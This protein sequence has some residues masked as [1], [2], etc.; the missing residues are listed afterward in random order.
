MLIDIYKAL[1]QVSYPV[2]IRPYIKKRIKI[3]KEDPN[4]LNERLGQP[5]L[6]RPEGKLIWMHGASVGETISML[7]LIDKILKEDKNIHVMVT[8]G[9]VTSADVMSKRLPERAFHQYIPIDNPKFVKNFIQHWQPDLALWFEAE[10]WPSLISEIHKNKIPLVLVNGRIADKAFKHWKMFKFFSKEM[11]DCF[12]LCLGQ[13]KEDTRRLNAIGAKDAQYLGNLKYAG[14][15]PPVDADKKQNIVN[16][17]GDRPLWGVISTHNNEEEQ[18]GQYIAEMKKQIPN[19]FT[20][21]APRHPQRGVT[22]Q[23]QL[24]KLGLNTALR[25]K[26]EPI[27]AKTDVYIADTIGEVGIWYD[28]APIIFIGGSLI[29]HGGQNFIEP[30]RFHD[31]VFVGPNTQNF[32]EATERATEAQAITQVKDAKELTQK[33]VSLLQNA[34]ELKDKQEKAYLWAQSEAQVLDG[35]VKVIKEYL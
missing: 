25:S 20:L 24:S 6:P 16:Q 5:K 7:P 19:L 11:L 22:I 13:S 35:I 17:I 18:I 34:N 30:C 9:T 23:E 32:T 27:E 1:I 31:A 14:F 28:I 33:V 21:I 26:N 12:D 3:G 29:P 4:R 15:N 2:F 8:S 10:L